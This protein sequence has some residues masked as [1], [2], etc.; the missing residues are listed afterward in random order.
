VSWHKHSD[1]EVME[2]W[3]AHDWQQRVH[4]TLM[5]IAG[6]HDAAVEDRL[7]AMQIFDTAVAN[8]LLPPDDRFP[9][10]CCR[11][12]LHITNGGTRPGSRRKQR[13]HAERLAGARMLLRTVSN[14]IPAE[15]QLQAKTKEVLLS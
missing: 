3:N 4:E 2:C 9:D 12:L 10:F 8:S 7:A 5:E 6:A 11:V 13:R 14:F 1:R 15:P